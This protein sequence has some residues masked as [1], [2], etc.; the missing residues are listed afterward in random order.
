MKQRALTTRHSR[1]FSWITF[2]IV[3]TE[4]EHPMD[5]Q[6]RQLIVDRSSSFLCLA[7]GGR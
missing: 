3:S 4:M 2:M 7:N 5:Q 1:R 6:H